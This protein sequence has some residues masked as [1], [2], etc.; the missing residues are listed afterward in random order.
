MINY[1][2]F[3][4]TKF[5]LEA[6]TSSL[7]NLCDKLLK[8]SN[9]SSCERNVRINCFQDNWTRKLAFWP[10]SSHGKLHPLEWDLFAHFRCGI[11]DEMFAQ[12]K[13][14]STK[15]SLWNFPTG[16]TR[17]SQKLSHNSCKEQFM[18]QIRC[19]KEMF[20]IL[21]QWGTELCCIFKHIGL[22]F[23]VTFHC[24]PTKYRYQDTR[25]VKAEWIFIKTLIFV[26]HED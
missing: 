25:C 22:K 6:I 2:A 7:S 15:K 1:C 18:H 8:C 12:N 9:C 16:I 20:F 19:I 23:V 4:K 13:M 5:P 17:R 26:C 3:Y 14:H 10:F 24:L 11:P 21:L